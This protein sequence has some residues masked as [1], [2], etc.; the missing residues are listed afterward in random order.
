MFHELASLMQLKD[1]LN[2]SLEKILLY[3]WTPE[4]KC[5]N[6]IFISTIILGSKG[7]QYLRAVEVKNVTLE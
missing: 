4:K 5:L 2:K 6:T 3:K 7:K 1:V